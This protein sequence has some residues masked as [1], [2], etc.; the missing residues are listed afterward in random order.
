MVGSSQKIKTF[1][2][3]FFSDEKLTTE[4]ESWTT[5]EQL[6]SWLLLSRCSSSCSSYFFY[7]LLSIKVSNCACLGCCC[8]LEVWRRQ[9]RAGQSLFSPM[10]AGQTWLALT[11]SWT[12]WLERKLKCCLLQEHPPL[13][14]LTT[15]SAAT[16]TGKP[17][18]QCAVFWGQPRFV[19]VTNHCVPSLLQDACQ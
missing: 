8:V 9:C 16:E 4:V 19:M 18:N 15:C 13:Q 1:C 12:C 3:I 11:L 14:T 17:L 2:D 10:R 7:L 6:A 5:G